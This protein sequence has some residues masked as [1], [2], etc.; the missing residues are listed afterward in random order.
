MVINKVVIVGAGPA[1]IGVASLLQKSGI[2]YIILEKSEIGASF[3]E[4][5]EYM[6]MITPSFPS[7]AFG[8]LDLNSICQTTSP[9]FSFNKEHLTGAEYAEYLAFVTVLFQ[10]NIELDIEVQKVNK[11]HDGWMLETNHGQYYCKYLIWA[12]GEF[13]NPVIENI[14]GA[15]HSLHSSSIKFPED[16]IEDEFIIIGGY[17]SGVQIAYELINDNKKV[18]LINPYKIDDRSTSDPSRILSPYTFEKY[19]KIRYSH[20][21][22]EVLGEVASISNVDDYY[23][24]RLRDES[25][26]RSKSK[27]I[28]A[29][30]FSLVK[31]PV[32]HLITYR[33]DGL[34]VLNDKS[35]EF[36][37][38]ENIYLSGPSVRHDHHIFCFIYKFRQRFGVV[39]EDI[40]KKENYD[41]KDIS[42]LI[43]IWKSTGMYL[44]DLNCC[45][46]ECVC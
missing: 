12:A 39:V 43:N 13:Q 14:A 2:D 15:Q 27:P 21:F 16:L 40:L 24:I 38:Q 11:H 35:D 5:P 18:V 41:K 1:G 23:D 26:L 30:G 3:T 31:K 4:W 37:G 6:E 22:D 34:P 25:I 17:E 32:D 7:N 45:D 9:A 28:C 44:S 20:L 42:S 46:V 10:L 33:A 19:D 8:Q 36:F 29:T